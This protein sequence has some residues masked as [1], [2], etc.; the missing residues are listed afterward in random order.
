M[1]KMAEHAATKGI[2]APVV[3]STYRDNASQA[4]AVATNW[5]IHGGG[6][7]WSVSTAY[8]YIT[9]LYGTSKGEKYHK[10]FLTDHTL[11]KVGT[12]GKAAATKML[13]AEQVGAP[14]KSHGANP[15]N[16]VDIRMQ[17][18]FDQLFASFT[19]VMPSQ[20]VMG[21]VT[22]SWTSDSGQKYSGRILSEKDH[23]HMTL[24]AS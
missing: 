14:P 2:P 18:T 13:D 8:A 6:S 19:G 12:A 21:S 16:A 17:T 23:R 3:G 1:R 9:K 11:G 10:A 22:F 20:T 4:S 7:S 15:S 5:Y 24:F